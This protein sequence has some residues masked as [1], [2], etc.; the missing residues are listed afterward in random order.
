MQAMMSR[1]SPEQWLGSVAKSPQRAIGFRWLSLRRVLTDIASPEVFTLDGSRLCSSTVSAH[2]SSTVLVCRA[3]PVLG[4]MFGCWPAAAQDKDLRSLRGHKQP[5][6]SRRTI[7]ISNK[8]PGQT[9]QPQPWHASRRSG[10]GKLHK[11]KV[12]AG[13]PEQWPKGPQG[14]CERQRRLAWQTS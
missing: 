4:H 13:F 2:R 10:L 1:S 5:S 14:P 11:M 3:A 7:T 6:R 12:S 9:N 8:L